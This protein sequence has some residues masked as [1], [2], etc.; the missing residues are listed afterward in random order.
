M[1]GDPALAGREHHD[2]ARLPD[3]ERGAHV[4]A[5]V[6]LLERHRVGLVL[7]EQRRDRRVDLGQPPLVRRLAR[8]LDHAAVERH[9]GAAPS[10]RRATT[11]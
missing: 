7:V 8:R 9:A 5:E 6:E 2:A 4:L 10:R 1:H 11:P 3:G